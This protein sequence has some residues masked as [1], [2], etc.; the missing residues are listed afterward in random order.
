MI[1]DCDPRKS[2]VEPF[3]RG[4]RA[5]AALPWSTKFRSIAGFDLVL[6]CQEN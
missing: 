4:L 6:L 1:F 3:G 2:F 5:E